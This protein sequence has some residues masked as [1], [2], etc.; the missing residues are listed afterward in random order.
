MTEVLT[1]YVNAAYTRS[2][3]RDWVRAGRMFV[4][5]AAYKPGRRERTGRGRSAQGEI[6]GR[7][8]RCRRPRPHADSV[9]RAER[10]VLDGRGRARRHVRRCAATL[11]KGLGERTSARARDRNPERARLLRQKNLSEHRKSLA[12]DAKRSARGGRVVAAFPRT[13]RDSLLVSG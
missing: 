9:R 6:Q 13:L 1:R 3:G 4:T 2:P 10:H 5:R 7:R 12:R 11:E 8:H